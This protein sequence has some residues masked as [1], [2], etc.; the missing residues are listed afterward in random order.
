MFIKLD[1]LLSVKFLIAKPFP[2]KVP[3]KLEIVW[4]LL[5]PLKS[6]SFNN[7]NTFVLFFLIK[8]KSSTLLIKYGLAVLPSPWTIGTLTL[9]VILLLLLLVILIVIPLFVPLL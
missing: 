5:T 8:S 9:K 2:S 1:W 3:L 6:I 4:K 7:L